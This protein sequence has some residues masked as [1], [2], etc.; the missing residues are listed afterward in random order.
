MEE[1]QWKSIGI[2]DVYQVSDA[3][4]VKNARTGHIKTVTYDFQGNALVYLYENHK[5]Q[6]KKVSRLVAES[7]LHGDVMSSYIHHIDGDRKHV[8]ADNLTLEPKSKGKKIKIVETGEVYDSIS[9][10]SKCIGLSRA[11]ISRCVGYPF[12]S[13]KFG[14]HFELI[15]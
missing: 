2:S 1:E 14:Y 4:R 15:D 9:E 5:K 11:R 3:G 10:A 12:N 7:F 6:K 8:S 13:N